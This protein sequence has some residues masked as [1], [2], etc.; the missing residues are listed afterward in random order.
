MA[1][2]VGPTAAQERL[3]V[4]LVNHVEDEPGDMA[5]MK[6]VA[7]VGAAERVGRVAAKEVVDHGACLSVRDV[8]AKDM[9]FFNV[10]SGRHTASPI[11]ARTR[12]AITGTFTTG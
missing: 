6:P 4:E 5:L 2:P 10:N 9:G 11:A 1:V 8:S 7:Q 3:Q 12:T